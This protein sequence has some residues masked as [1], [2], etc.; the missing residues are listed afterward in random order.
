MW[1]HVKCY[2][3][4]NKVQKSSLLS[5]ITLSLLAF[6]AQRT[7][8]GFGVRFIPEDLQFEETAVESWFLRGP[9]FGPGALIPSDPC[10]ESVVSIRSRFPGQEDRMAAAET[11]SSWAIM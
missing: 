5:V 3:T 6:A 10:P 11:R 4:S 2:V 1:F 8:E 7:S 9:G